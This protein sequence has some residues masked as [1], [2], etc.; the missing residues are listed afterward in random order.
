MLLLSSRVLQILLLFTKETTCRWPHGRYSI[1]H[2]HTGKAYRSML[3]LLSCSLTKLIGQWSKCS[4]IC[5]LVLFP[6]HTHT[7]LPTNICAINS[8]PPTTPLL[9]LLL[10]SFRCFTL[11]LSTLSLSLS[12]THVRPLLLTCALRCYYLCIHRFL[13]L[14]LLL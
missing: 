8:P 3:L 6:F 14:H 10:Q 4:H 1:P 9:L 12:P 7:H 11:S 5:W 2:T 13:S